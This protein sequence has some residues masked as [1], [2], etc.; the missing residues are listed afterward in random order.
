[1]K[2]FLTLLLF[3]ILCFTSKA[4][5]VIFLKSGDELKVKIINITDSTIN[6]AN[7]STN[8]EISSVSKSQVFK[9][10]YSNGNEELFVKKKKIKTN[11]VDDERKAAFYLTGSYNESYQIF[12]QLLWV[13]VTKETVNT[14]NTKKTQGV[15]G[16]QGNGCGWNA[17]FGLLFKNKIAFEFTYTNFTGNNILFA[18]STILKSTISNYSISEITEIKNRLDYT[19]YN[20]SIILKHKWFYSKIG[21]LATN[22]TLYID[23]SYSRKSTGLAALK[24]SSRISM[25]KMTAPLQ[26]GFTGGLGIQI[27]IGKHFGLFTEANLTILN[28]KPDKLS[29][30][31]VTDNNK[32]K[33]L[34]SN[35]N[36]VAE[37]D[38]AKVNELITK[39]IPAY[40]WGWVVG[41]RIIF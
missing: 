24:D 9:I 11:S 41:L 19:A 12:N 33:P 6:Y 22:S 27:L 7:T 28:M 13:N 40:S 31:N 2:P 10:R 5:D 18:N 34:P 1:M 26:Y 30:I 14:T 4:Q 8:N 23:S 20:G 16:T 17:G 36:L 38:G 35:V 37:T 39:P 15:Y 29:F 21:I 25:S 32:P 3:F